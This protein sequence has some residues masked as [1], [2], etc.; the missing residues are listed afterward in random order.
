[1][2]F[3]TNN[4]DVLISDDCLPELDIDEYLAD[5]SLVEYEGPLKTG[6]VQ[7][8]LA[9][10]SVKSLCWKIMFENRKNDFAIDQIKEADTFGSPAAAE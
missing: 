1:M 6:E 4:T 7:K 5:R 8:R 10:N 3:K 9:F 2:I